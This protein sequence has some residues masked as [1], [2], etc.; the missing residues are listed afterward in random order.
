MIRSSHVMRC[1]SCDELVSRVRQAYHM[2]GCYQMMYYCKAVS[3]EAIRCYQM[4]CLIWL[5]RNGT[6]RG[7][8]GRGSRRASSGR[9]VCETFTSFRADAQL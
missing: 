5:L 7:R 8:V 2:T 6:P 9:A 3:Q 4:M 1:P